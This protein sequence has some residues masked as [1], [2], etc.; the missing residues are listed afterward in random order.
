M[1]V[2]EAYRN[3]AKALEDANNA[4]KHEDYSGAL[5]HA[6]KVLE[7]LG[8]RSQERRITSFCEERLMPIIGETKSRAVEQSLNVLRDIAN[9]SSHANNFSTDRAT[10]TYVIETLAINLRYNSTVLL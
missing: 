1:P 6:R 4:F 3:A 2:P 10:A 8:N 7:H 5:T 9:T